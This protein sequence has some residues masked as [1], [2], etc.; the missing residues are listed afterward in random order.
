MIQ[1]VANT[2]V[3]IRITVA[4]GTKVGRNPHLFFYKKYKKEVDKGNIW[5]I[6]KVLIEEDQKNLRDSSL[7]GIR[8]TLRKK[9]SVPIKY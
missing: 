5:C 7:V 9:N 3:I 1:S 8:P 4:E 6:I 2:S